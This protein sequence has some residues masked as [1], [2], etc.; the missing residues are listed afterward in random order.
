MRP[1][2]TL[3]VIVM[4][5][6]GAL[7]GRQQANFFS[8][9]SELV[10]L[11][12]I[13]SDRDGRFVPDLPRDRFIVYD[14]GRRQEVSLFSNE[15]TPVSI[16]ILVDNSRSMAPKMGEVV[17]A[18]LAFARWS[19]PEDEVFV[20]AFNDT[21][22]DVTAG[23]WLSAADTK[24]LE[25]TLA[26]L[27]PAGRTAMYDAVVTALDRLNDATR[28]RK[29]LIVVSDGGDNASRST[30]KDALARARQSNVTMYAIGLFDPNDADTNPGVLKKLAHETGGERFLPDSP[31][32]MLQICQHIAREIRS[33]YTL[34][35]VPPD[36]DG[37]FHRIRVDVQSPGRDDR[38]LVIRTRP[39]YFAAGRSTSD[40]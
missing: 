36:H 25:S 38:R 12:V 2:L 11:P 16:G 24:E 21:A 8:G 40:K 17:A 29:V 18:S 19:N 5:S 27:R 13:V 7:S 14:N 37:A 22:Q 9:S 23:R 6:G 10:V 28:P 33:G 30:L 31:G 3:A 26:S 1:V 32:R 34:G 15:D 35:Y 39:G 20:I 4:T